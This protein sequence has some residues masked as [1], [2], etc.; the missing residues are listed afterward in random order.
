MAPVSMTD[1]QDSARGC[2]RCAFGDSAARGG[3][4]AG[5]R[6]CA[7]AA[8]LFLFPPVLAIVAAVAAGGPG[9]PG[10]RQLIAGVLGFVAGAILAAVTAGM[11][12]RRRGGSP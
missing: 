10:L 5:W 6:L 11:L 8:G 3:E 2:G 4:P 9:A 1:E 12:N 7:A